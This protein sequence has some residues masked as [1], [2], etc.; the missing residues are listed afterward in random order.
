MRTNS[1]LIRGRSMTNVKKQ[2]LMG[3]S[4]LVMAIGAGAAHA[5]TPIY[6]GGSTLSAPYVRQAE[7]CYGQQAPLYTPGGV[8]AT[9]PPPEIFTITVAG[10]TTVT[11]CSMTQQ[12]P[13]V[14]MF[15][16]ASGS[17]AGI[18]S[19]FDHNGAALGTYTDENN[20]TGKTFPTLNYATSDTTL[21][22]PSVAV[23]DNGGDQEPASKKNVFVVGQGVIPDGSHF[24][25]PLLTYGPMVQV[26]LLITPV[27]VAFSPVYK[28]VRQGDGTE[29]TYSFNITNLA[30]KGVLRLDLETYCKIFNGQITDWNDASIRALNGKK[31]TVPAVRPTKANGMTSIPG[32]TYYMPIN[33]PNDPDVS[34]ITNGTN[35]FSL[36]IEL[37]GRADGSGT[38]NIFSRALAAQCNLADVTNLFPNAGNT[39]P[40][41]VLGPLEAT[42][43]GAGNFDADAVPGTGKFT[44]RSGS[45]GVAG[46]MQFAADAGPNQGDEV[47]SGKIAYLSPD[48]VNPVTNKYGLIYAALQN[49]QNFVTGGLTKTYVLPTAKAAAASYAGILAPSTPA[50]VADPSQW[51]QAPDKSAFIATPTATTGYPIVGTTQILLYTCYADTQKNSDVNVGYKL[52][53]FLYFYLK[54]PIVTAP[55][56]T[57]PVSLG[58]ILN[59]YGFAPMPSAFR[60]AEYNAFVKPGTGSGAAFVNN[61]TQVSPKS[62]LIQANGNRVT[63]TFAHNRACDTVPGA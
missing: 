43:D 32:Y 41:A 5:Q 15:I 45:G 8:A 11:D 53:R 16:E 40:S 54:N 19:F 31:V 6:G 38:S 29:L 23:Y 12:D 3:A 21:G 18:L 56:T 42:K 25:N 17:G 33:D 27:T 20:N 44:T 51:V 39:L 52:N 10:V 7:D 14:K 60:T 48:Y 30:N 13:N 26:P 34:P 1:E 62:D 47:T 55:G 22:S 63:V 36:P 58:G 28:K 9:N 49:Y 57:I 50:T 59:T 37:V 61:P 4:A 46:Y 24:P 2:A 35:N